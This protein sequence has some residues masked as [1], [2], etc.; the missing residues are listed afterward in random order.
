MCFSLR[1]CSTAVRAR[2]TDPE[3][4][5]ESL[6][7]LLRAAMPR[8]L[9]L[10]SL[11][12]TSSSYCLLTSCSSLLFKI[13]MALLR[14]SCILRLV[15]FYSCWRRPMRVCILRTSSSSRRRDWRTSDAGNSLFM[16]LR[17]AWN[18]FVL[19]VELSFGLSSRVLPPWLATFSL[20]A[21]TFASARVTEI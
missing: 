5:V 18:I 2:I 17:P 6:W 20:S 10:R 11:S 15:R 13:P 3:T 8:R 19:I 1:K 7:L 4:S 21:L 14:A 12:R 16:L 9:R